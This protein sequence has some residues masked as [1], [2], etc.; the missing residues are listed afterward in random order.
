MAELSKSSGPST[1]NTP[2]WFR[3]SR[4]KDPSNTGSIVFTALRLLELP[5][6]Y[7]FIKSGLATSLLSRLGATTMSLPQ[8]STSFLGLGL[9]P[10][11]TLILSLA[12]GTS[13]SQIFWAWI[14]R[15]NYFPPSGATAIA[16]YNTL[17]NT[18]N[19]AFALWAVTSQVPAWNIRSDTVGSWPVSVAAG[20]VLYLTGTVMERYS[21]VQRKTF[22]AKPENKGKPFAGGLFGV[23][24]NANYTGYT[25]MRTGFALVCG[26]W[27]W[28]TVMGGTVFSDFA[29]RA[30]PW[31]EG[32]CEQR[33]RSTGYLSHCRLVLT[34]FAVRPT[35]ARSQE[36]GAV[37]PS[38]GHLLDFSI[39]TQQ[40][41]TSGWPPHTKTKPQCA[42]LALSGSN[43]ALQNFT[44]VAQCET[45]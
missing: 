39:A 2:A 43:G 33:V 24:R 25:L 36:E 28:G 10:Y 29:F 6:Q 7:Y 23:V 32:Y 9:H 16:L 5:W 15:D 34:R 12:A 45:R 19:S 3:E 27:A 1:P 35:V 31:L 17:L 4:K 18:V 41:F 30:V 44:A 21:E 26:G 37:P 22:K 13:A 8:P 11:Q 40:R 20:V 42:S 38:S 14:V